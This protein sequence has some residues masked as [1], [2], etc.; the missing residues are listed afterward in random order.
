M[1]KVIDKDH[2]EIT[3][4]KVDNFTR[5]ELLAKKEKYE[6]DLAKSQAMFIDPLVA[7]LEKNNEY[8]T[9]MDAYKEK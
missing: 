6:K 9:L 3:T 7:E 2:I 8:L 1:I 5:E 4:A